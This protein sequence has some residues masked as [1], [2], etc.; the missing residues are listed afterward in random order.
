MGTHGKA[1]S[2]TKSVMSLSSTAASSMTATM[3]LHA[4]STISSTTLKLRTTEGMKMSPNDMRSMSIDMAS[5]QHIHPMHVG[6]APIVHDY[7]TK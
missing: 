3:V 4:P 7:D 1:P 5:Q 6:V 2:L